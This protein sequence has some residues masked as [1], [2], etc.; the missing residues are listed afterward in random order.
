MNDTRTDIKKPEK[1]SKLVW[2]YSDTVEGANGT[3]YKNHTKILEPI[4]PTEKNSC[5]KGLK[6]FF[7]FL[8]RIEKRFNKK[9]GWFFTNGMKK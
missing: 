6:S 7:D 4:A 5:Q 9:Y 1:F 3:G 2:H 8:A